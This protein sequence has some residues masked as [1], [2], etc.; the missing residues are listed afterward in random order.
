MDPYTYLT[1]HFTRDA[2]R[3]DVQTPYG[4]YRGYVVGDVVWVKKDG[5]VDDSDLAALSQLSLGQATRV[6][7]VPDD[8]VSI[9]VKWTCDSTD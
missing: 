3:A 4:P 9:R 1:T 7:R 6:S 2:T 8:L 5:L